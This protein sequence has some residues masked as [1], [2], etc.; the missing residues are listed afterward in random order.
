MNKDL[1]IMISRQVVQNENNLKTV[2]MVLQQFLM[3]IIFNIINDMYSG[4]SSF[5]NITYISTNFYKNVIV[6]KCIIFNLNI[7]SS[8]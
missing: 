4:D 6:Q 1:K 3:E 5:G 2:S 8:F 7:L